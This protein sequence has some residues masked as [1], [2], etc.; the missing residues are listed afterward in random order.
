VLHELN[1][2]TNKKKKESFF[3]N[4]TPRIKNQKYYFLVVLEC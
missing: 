4:F 2:T 1:K 3:I